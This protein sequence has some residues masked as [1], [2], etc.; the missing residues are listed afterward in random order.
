MDCDRSS[1]DLVFLVLLMKG[2]QGINPT[3]P[4]VA[5]ITTYH[6]PKKK[7][8]GIHASDFNLTVIIGRSAKLL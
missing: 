2:T 7:K 8:G 6:N 4:E 5:T 1:P 3:I